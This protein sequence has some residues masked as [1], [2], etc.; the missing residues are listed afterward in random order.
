M[1]A[2]FSVTFLLQVWER[3]FDYHQTEGTYVLLI[4]VGSEP[5]TLALVEGLTVLG[6]RPD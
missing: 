3:P 4:C 6:S 5:V 2:L 1:A